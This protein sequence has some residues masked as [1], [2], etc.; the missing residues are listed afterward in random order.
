M[1]PVLSVMSADDELATGPRSFP[2]IYRPFAAGMMDPSVVDRSFVP[3]SPATRGQ[4]AQLVEHGPEK[5]GV[6][7]SS[8]P[9]STSFLIPFVPSC[10][11]V[12]LRSSGGMTG[13]DRPFVWLLAPVVTLL[14]W[15]SHS[16]YRLTRASGAKKKPPTSR[17][18]W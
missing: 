9:L 11:M 8:P 18:R 16:C 2:G 12:S 15:P 14:R 10:G 3:D 1:L 17:Q 4:V 6:G 7:G 13:K 5:A